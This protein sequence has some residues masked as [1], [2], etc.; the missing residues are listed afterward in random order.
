MGLI[1]NKI[2]SLL[3]FAF[4]LSM[5][6]TMFANNDFDPSGLPEGIEVEFCANNVDGLS[7]IFEN[8]STNP[9]ISFEW[10]MGDGTIIQE[11]NFDYTYQD[12]GHY[13]VCMKIKDAINAEVIFKTCKYVTVG[14]ISLCEFDWEPVCGC[15]QR[16][17]TNPCIAE[18]YHGVYF[19]TPGRCPDDIAPVLIPEY[20]YSVEARKIDFINS[21]IG[22]YD[23]FKWD[24]GDGR[25][26]RRRNPSHIYTH[27]GPYEICL[28]IIHSVT[29]QQEKV[30]EKV[31]VSASK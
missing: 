7:V 19:W 29:E 3:T 28:T 25:S 15:D 13:Y 23:R 1:I 27:D 18:T 9:A 31:E 20:T 17:Y 16:T 8:N 2:S 14:D 5:P 11:Q 21:S 30:C 4:T 24:F 10:D 12:I 6:F 26:S 22:S